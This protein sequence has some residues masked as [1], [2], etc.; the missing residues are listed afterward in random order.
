RAGLGG[1]AEAKVS[2]LASN[3]YAYHTYIELLLRQHQPAAAFA[4][5]EKSKARVLLD[6]LAAGSVDLNKGV[7]PEEQ[8]RVQQLRRQESLL[9]Q[10]LVAEKIKPA[11]DK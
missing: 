7:T 11:P 4:W 3:L 8:Q 10:Q 5:A 6:L 9:N 1:L 2:F